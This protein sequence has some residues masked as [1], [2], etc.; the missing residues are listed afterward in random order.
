MTEEYSLRESTLPSIPTPHDCVISAIE[1]DGEDLCFRFEEKK[2]AEREAIREKHP[3]ASAL[4]MRFHMD[5]R[6]R[7][8]FQLLEQKHPR[9]DAAYEVKKYKKLFKL[10]EPRRKLTY[11]YHFVAFGRIIITMSSD[12]A[13]VQLCFSTDKVT[14]DWKE[15]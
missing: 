5:A 8:V 1:E 15:E 9:D 13:N 7:P 6:D 12:S 2:L 3:R 4:V 11:Q 10:A 14:L